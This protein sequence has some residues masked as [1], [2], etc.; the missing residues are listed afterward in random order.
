ME[1]FQ[2]NIIT[3]IVFNKDWHCC[4][5]W[6]E[7]QTKVSYSCM[8]FVIYSHMYVNGRLCSQMFRVIQFIKG[9]KFIFMHLIS[10]A[11]INTINPPLPPPPTHMYTHTQIIVVLKYFSCVILYAH[12]LFQP[13]FKNK[14]CVQRLALSFPFKIR[15]CKSETTL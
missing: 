15:C 6:H 11:V 2:T 12:V 14:Y 3:N 9:K 7:T 1:L 8:C 13:E 4:Y 5:I 10:N